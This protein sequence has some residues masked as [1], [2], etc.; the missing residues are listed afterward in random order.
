MDV[1]V[2][3]CDPQLSREGVEQIIVSIARKDR[4]EL[5]MSE[6]D[7]RFRASARHG[8]PLQREPGR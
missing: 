2:S 7:S 1:N 8:G 3:R 4:A 5:S 6:P